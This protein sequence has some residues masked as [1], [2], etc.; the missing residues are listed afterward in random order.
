MDN[1]EKNQY[2]VNTVSP[3]LGWNWGAFMYNYLF[4]FANHA[5]LTF[6]IFIPMLNIIWIFVSGAMGASWAWN[7]GKFKNAETFNAVMESWNRA[8]LLMLI[9]TAV[10]MVLTFI[11]LAVTG[12][13]LAGLLGGLASE[14]NY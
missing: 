12:I 4:G 8:G 2:T 13:G 9:V 11:T 3:N 5:Y 14:T 7:S 6:L 10:T 1:F